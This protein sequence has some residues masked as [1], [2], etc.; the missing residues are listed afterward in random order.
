MVIEV[1][2]Q[3]NILM[4]SGYRPPNTSTVDFSNGY[5]NVLKN[6]TNHKHTNS[7]IGIDH[8]LDFIKHNKHNPTQLYLTQNLDYHMVPTIT[9]PTR[10]TDN[11]ATLIDNLFVSQ[12]LQD[13]YKSS[14]LINDFSDHLPCYVILQDVT[15]LKASLQTVSFHRF[16]EKVKLKICENIRKIDWQTEL[17][18]DDV[19]EAFSKF[20]SKLTNLIKKFAPVKTKT[21]NPRKH[22]RAKWLTAGIINS[23]NKNKEL[24]RKSI[25]TSASLESKNQYTMHNKL[26][27]KI[28]RYAKLNYYSNKCEEIRNNGSKL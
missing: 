7:V 16:S 27:N 21:I 26:L 17:T 6:M 11:S 13:K 18:N 22:P 19:N 20:H 23:I 8:N 12:K 2:C 25:Q 10:I 1:K 4:C 15:E 5:E 28:K 24:Y 3:T 14:I 9:R